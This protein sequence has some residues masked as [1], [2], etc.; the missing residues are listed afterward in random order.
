MGRK[1]GLKNHL[2][3]SQMDRGH[4]WKKVKFNAF[5]THFGPP[6]GWHALTKAP[7]NAAERTPSRQ[8]PRLAVRV[9]QSDGWKPPEVG[10]GAGKKCPQNCV[11]VRLAGDM[12]KFWFRP[13]GCKLGPNRPNSHHSRQKLVKTQQKRSPHVA[14]VDSVHEQGPEIPLVLVSEPSGP[15]FGDFGPFWACFGPRPV[16]AEIVS[17]GPAEAQCRRKTRTPVRKRTSK[18]II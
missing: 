15:V 16:P 17:F 14:R 7:Q 13:A 2:Q 6:F 12:A 9:G 4:V 1:T 8:K 5:L 10:V 3:A 18:M 11:L